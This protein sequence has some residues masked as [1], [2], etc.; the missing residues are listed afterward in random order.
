MGEV[1]YAIG[2]SRE[3]VEPTESRPDGGLKLLFEYFDEK[4]AVY[5]IGSD[6][7]E[8][9]NSITI[10]ADVMADCIKTAK[11]FGYEYM[12]SRYITF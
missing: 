3:Q 4:C 1:K 10:D 11:K 2:T 9:I 7:R 12:L 8:F 5:W 6:R